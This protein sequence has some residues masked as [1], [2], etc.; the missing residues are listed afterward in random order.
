MQDQRDIL[1]IRQP[2]RGG[3]RRCARQI[4][5]PRWTL[6]SRMQVDY[7]YPDTR[8][9]SQRRTI[10]TGCDEKRLRLEIVQVKEELLLAIG[11]IEWSCR[12]GGCSGE[13]GGNHLWAVIK[14]DRELVT[15][16]NAKIVER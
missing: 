5:Q 8:S 12:T 1:R 3:R 6:R 11:W 9:R 4:K 7:R 15:P 14:N 10:A 16:A 13:E 2:R